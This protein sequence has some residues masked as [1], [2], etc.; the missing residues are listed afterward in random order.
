MGLA[1][2]LEVIR[3]RWWM[4][5]VSILLC[6]GSSYLLASRTPTWYEATATIRVPWVPNPNDHSTDLQQVVRRYQNLIREP[7]ILEGAAQAAGL[8]YVPSPGNVSARLAPDSYLLEIIVRDTDPE[9]ACALAD[10]VAQQLVEQQRVLPEEKAR[11]DFVQ[12][13]LRS[14]KESIRQT[15]EEIGEEAVK[16]AAA[17][18]ER[19]IQ[20]Y[21]EKIAA[22]QQKLASYQS[23]HASLVESS[24][25]A[26]EQP[27]RKPLRPIRTLPVPEALLL[28]AALG[29]ILG[30]AGA[31]FLEFRAGGRAKDRE[32]TAAGGGS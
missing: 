2:F 29:L 22:L 30:L 17:D 6:T 10:A 14:L 7:A 24:R 4:V 28:A 8:P 18:S 5:A 16:L 21:Q 20:Q 19:A 12:S 13:Q 9:H 27:A 23:N 3:R 31:F 25:I 32:S 26:I 15:E 11:Q 1:Y